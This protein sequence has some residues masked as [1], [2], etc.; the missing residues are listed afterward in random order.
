[1]RVE[2]VAVGSELLLGQIADTNSQWLGEQLAAAGLASHFHRTS[3]TTTSASCW[4]CGP[5]WRAR[6]P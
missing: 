2:V 6:T 1:M 3:A 4:R 5:R